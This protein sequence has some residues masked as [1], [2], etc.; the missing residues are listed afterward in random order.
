M[1][2]IDGTDIIFG[3]MASVLAKKALEGEEVYLINAEKIVLSGNPKSIIDKYAARKAAKH[4][5]N[6]EFSPK[7]PKVPHM[8]VKRMIRGM[9]SFRTSR[10]RAAYK[11]VIV[12]TG[13]PKELKAAEFG[14]RKYDGI[15]PHITIERLCQMIGHQG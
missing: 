1:I 12:Y 15:A 8:L 6:P 10:G 9:L 4:T 13:N 7:W 14:F 5:G 11:R 2:I 3:R